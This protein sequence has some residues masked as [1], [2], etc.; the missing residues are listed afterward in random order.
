MNDLY[1]VLEGLSEI[2]E[3]GATPPVDIFP[4]FRHI[5]DSLFNNWRSR[6]R[7]VEDTMLNLYGPLVD[8]VLQRREESGSRSTYL[9][10]VL[11]QQEKLQLT[12]HE[13]DL[14]V[15]N[16]LEGGSDTSSIMTIAFIQ[17]MAC[18]PEMQ[19]EA[20]REIDAVFGEDASPNWQDYA[21]LPYVAMVVKETM[22]WRPVMPTGFPHATNK[23]MFCIS[24]YVDRM[25]TMIRNHDRW[26]DHTREQYCHHQHLGPAPRSYQT[27]QPRRL[28]PPPIPG[29]HRACPCVRLS[30]KR[31]EPRPFWLR[32]WAADL[33]GNSSCGT[34]VVRGDCQDS[35]GI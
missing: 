7:R 30:S 33:S 22:R 6:S 23:G 14:M 11:D 3:M 29:P 31:R 32:L 26:Y 34:D 25:L 24:G 35:V 8:R 10:G 5:P 4:I 28:Q 21:R 20:Q 13:I 2:F 19:Q 27:P 1:D 12:R 16:L 15:G 9:D 18:Y 17:A